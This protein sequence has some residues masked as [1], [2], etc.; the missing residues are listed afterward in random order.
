MKLIKRIAQSVLLIV[1][2]VQVSL[3]IAQLAILNHLDIIDHKINVR[4]RM[5]I[6]KHLGLF[7]STVTGHVKPVILIG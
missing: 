3:I 1:L 4:V 7:V 5:V 2:N 6:L